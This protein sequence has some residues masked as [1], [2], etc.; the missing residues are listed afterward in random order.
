MTSWFTARAAVISS[1]VFTLLLVFVYRF[2][3]FSRAVVVADGM[4]LFLL[5]TG[6]RVAFRMMRRSMPGG[7]QVFEAASSSQQRVLIYGAG[8]GGEM[9]LREVRNNA[10]LNYKAVGFLDDDPLKKNKVING[11][12]VFGRWHRRFQYL[13]TSHSESNTR[14]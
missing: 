4:L 9:L 12:R 7:R 13:R 6:S 2:D 5:L 11:L 10:A 8:D 1:L 3:G 14:V